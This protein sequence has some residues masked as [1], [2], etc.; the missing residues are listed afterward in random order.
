MRAEIV[1]ARCGKRP[2][3]GEAQRV[4]QREGGVH[5]P[6]AGAFL[7]AVIGAEREETGARRAPRRKPRWKSRVVRRVE[8]R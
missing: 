1:I 6:G 7:A 5:L 3:I 2:L 4:I 8:Y